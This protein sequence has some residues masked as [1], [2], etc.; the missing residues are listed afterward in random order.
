MRYIAVRNKVLL[1]C[2]GFKGVRWLCCSRSD[3]QKCCGAKT[4]DAGIEACSGKQ[5]Q[6]T[7]DT[8]GPIKAKRKQ[9]GKTK[10]YI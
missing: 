10:R 7:P 4:L 9:V 3:R 6:E 2:L 1:S 8:V 5:S